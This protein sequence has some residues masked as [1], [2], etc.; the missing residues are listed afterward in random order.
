MWLCRQAG[1]RQTPHS[2]LHSG[3]QASGLRALAL[4]APRQPPVAVSRSEGAGCRQPCM[5][6]QPSGASSKGGCRA[7]AARMQLRRDL[8]GRA[9]AALLER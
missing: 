2:Q 7:V 4:A 1:P 8:H 5:P 6:R 3:G 9:E